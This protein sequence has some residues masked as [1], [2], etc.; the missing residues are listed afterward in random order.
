MVRLMKN[1][2]IDAVLNIWKAENIR[3][4]SFIPKEYWERS[5]DF[6]KGALPKA[7]V[8]VYEENGRISGFIGLDGSYI[9]GIFVDSEYHGKGIG[10]ALLNK[11]KEIKGALILSVYRKNANAVR[12]YE[13]RGFVIANEGIDEVTGETEFEMVLK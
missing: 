5:F 10:T 12:F 6:V 4:H 1:G 2:D 3:A 7:E 11:A 13:N 9:E 8:Y